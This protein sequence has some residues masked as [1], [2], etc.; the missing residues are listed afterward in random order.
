MS[1]LKTQPSTQSV[2]D[3][4]DSVASEEKRDDSRV[5]VKI[6][7][8]ITGE[9]PVMWGS[10]IV[11]FGKYHYK[12]DSGRE[13]DWMIAGFSPRKQNMTIYMMGGFANQDELLAKIGKAKH[14]V[15]CL[16]IKK[17]E[18][19]DLEVLKEMIKLSVLTIKQRYADFN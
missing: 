7:E 19:I 9:Q 3:F 10:S 11:G 6:M 15:G 8:Q 5:L 18:D 17:L 1:T 2:E 4:I 14:S 13:G 12:Y 16:Y